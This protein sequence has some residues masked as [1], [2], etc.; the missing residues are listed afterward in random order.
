LPIKP[1]ERSYLQTLR[2]D[3]PVAQLWQALTEPQALL[4]WHAKSARV[5]PRQGGHYAYRSKL[6]GDRLARIQDFEPGRRL[7]LMFEPNPSW[8]DPGGS[9][10]VEDFLLDTRGSGRNMSSQLRIIG[11]GV[12]T[13]ATWNATYRRLQAGWAVAFSVLQRLLEA[14]ELQRK[15]S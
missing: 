3:A 5:E 9:V 1:A 2:C 15:A 11:S 4:L 12:P 14:G 8:P 7:R 13:L 6:F 10:I